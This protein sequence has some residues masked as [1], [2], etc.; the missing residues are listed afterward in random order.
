M[1]SRSL[2]EKIENL[3]DDAQLEP[4][5]YKKSI[6]INMVIMFKVCPFLGP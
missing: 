6:D 3:M 4:L 1:N 5:L 2:V